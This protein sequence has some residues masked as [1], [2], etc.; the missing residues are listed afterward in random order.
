MENKNCAPLIPT[1]ERCHGFL[2]STEAAPPV[3]CCIQLED[4]SI[5]DPECFCGLLGG[6]NVKEFPSNKTVAAKIVSLCHLESVW[7]PCQDSSVVQVSPRQGSSSG[8]FPHRRNDGGKLKADAGWV[9]VET[10]AVIF[11]M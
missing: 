3:D 10:L 7:V 11:L 1:V 5:D 6:S 4:L 8:S 2:R 9:L